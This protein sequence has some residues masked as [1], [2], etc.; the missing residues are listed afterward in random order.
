METPNSIVIKKETNGNILI[1]PEGAQYTVMSNSTISKGI[2]RVVVRQLMTQ[3]PAIV[4]TVA[5]VEKV[6]HSNGTEVSI[7]DVDTLFSELN[8][9]FF[10]ESVEGS[11]SPIHPLNEVIIN[12]DS[13]LDS[14]ETGGEIVVEDNMYYRFGDSFTIT[15]PFKLTS[16]VSTTT[17]DFG[18]NSMTYSGSGA[19]FRGQFTG[20]TVINRALIFGNGTN[21]IWDV[22]GNSNPAGNVLQVESISFVGF[23][24][25]GTI[26]SIGA[27]NHSVLYANT[28][29]GLIIKGIPILSINNSPINN[30]TTSNSPQIVLDGT[31][32]SVKINGSALDIQNSESFLQISK[33]VIITGEVVIV[34]NQFSNSL[35]G[36]FLATAKSNTGVTFSDNGSGKLRVLSAAHGLTIEQ[37]VSI[38]NSTL[39]NGDHI[40]LTVVDVGTFDLDTSFLGADSG[41]WTTGDSN[42]FLDNIK[43]EFRSNG[44]QKD[45]NEICKFKSIATIPITIASPSTDGTNAVDII[46]VSG[47]W[48]GVIDRRFVFQFAGDPAGTTR[49]I[50]VKTL[51]FRLSYRITANPSGGASKKMAGY[52]TIDSGSGAVTQVDSKFISSSGDS[53]TLNPEDIFTLNTNDVIGNSIENQT[54]S[55]NI[56][57]EFVNGNIVKA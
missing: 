45:S 2:D 40:V 27:I 48:A 14:L 32:G 5:A 55:T 19:L 41:D 3:A 26:D 15:R 21:Q 6:V 22:S 56:D 52:I 17:L 53:T 47:N 36:E 20:G 37:C 44:D 28:G 43:F 25:K 30:S 33:N 29:T 51:D 10:F 38:S 9:F 12:S 16:I 35:G 13:D 24:N 1:T 39:H 23:A 34:A 7:S 57:V 11:G 31:F 50:G 42:D 8:E 18:N 54:D 4:F 49:Y 46:G